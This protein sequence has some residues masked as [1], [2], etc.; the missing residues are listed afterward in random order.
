MKFRNDMEFRIEKHGEIKIAG[1]KIAI[2]NEKQQGYK[3]I[4]KMWRSFA[5]D[6]DTRNKL[7]SLMDG[8]PKG[9]IGANVYNVDP[10]DARKFDYYIGTATN[11][12]ELGDFQSYTIPARTW[13]IFPCKAKDIAKT[14][15][16]VVA[17]WEPS[18][19][20]RVLNT[21]YTTGYME[22]QAPD[23]EVYGMG[24]MAEVW[25]AVEKK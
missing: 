13:A 17:K 3:A 11:V 16:N 14:E 1:I 4:P 5:K 7:L 9:M 6:E 18:S 19:E 21:G 8:E 24:D 22:G 25:V 23:L 20:Y 12:I 2:T 10:S 15:F